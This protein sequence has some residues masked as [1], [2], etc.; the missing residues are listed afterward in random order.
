MDPVL[1]A[2]GGLVTLLVLLVLRVPIAFALCAVAISGLFLVFAWPA[3][4]AFNPG[5][6]VRPLTAFLATEPFSFVKTYAFT[7]VPLFIALGHI[8]HRARFTTDLFYA[9]R[10]L[11]PNVPGGLAMASVIGCGGFASISG[12]SVACASAMG[13]IAV[14]EMLKYGYSKA[15]ATASVAAGGTL[16][17]LIPPS[18]VLV[19]FGIFTEQSIGMLF[20]AGIIPGVLSVLSY[21][22]VIFVWG[23]LKPSSA[24]VHRAHTS[25]R[26]KLVATARI[27]PIALI[28]V[29]VIGGIYLGVLTAT[30]AA[31]LAAAVALVLG[32]ILKRLD[33]ASIIDALVETSYQTALIFAIA[34]GAKLLVSFVGLTGVAG[35]TV[36]WALNQGLSPF[37]IL[38]A[39]CILYLI[40]GTFLDAVGILLLTLP[41]TAPIIESL[42]YNLVWFGIVVVKLIEIGLVTPPVGMNVFVIKA[43]VGNQVSLQQIFKGVTAFILADLAILWLLLTYPQVA[44]LLPQTMY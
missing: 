1:L 7:M 13:R 30:E 19:L 36:D 41:F 6:A 43:V 40:L 4:Q 28:S 10:V 3:G 24:P 18:L 14:P 12:S 37:E 5:R 23:R 21:I 25:F 9:V 16:G 17:S 15:L 2:T 26:E 34:I 29:V 32:L 11:L 31:A 42:G 35:N 22:V 33:L 44:L 8:A 27:W 38:L 20:I 39:I